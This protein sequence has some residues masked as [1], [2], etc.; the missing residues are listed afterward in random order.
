MLN[1]LIA[2]WQRRQA[3]R[4]LSHVNR[5]EDERILFDNSNL[6]EQATNAMARGDLVEV[7]KCWT[8]IRERHPRLV[9][10]NHDSLSIMLSLQLYDEAEQVMKKGLKE[11][12]RDP[13]Y[14][15]GLAQISQRR[16]N[17]A[18][19]N[20]QWTKIRRSYPSRFPA[21][22]FGAQALKELGRLADAERLTSLAISRFPDGQ[23]CTACW[24]EHARVAEAAQKW[25]L[26]LER[27]SHVDFEC[28]HVSGAIGAARALKKLGQPTEAK[29][30]LLSRTYRYGNEHEF[31]I[32]LTEMLD[33][34]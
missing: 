9:M 4:E 25:N 23:E 29:E 24:I 8:S 20:R 22:L 14:R 2:W 32:A 26:A 17:F 6:F 18:A 10:S 30:R 12:P 5:R 1:S 31:K 13:H 34:R 33:D 28:C 3:F 7:S 11:H 21:Y 16:G 27:W 19:S 15:E